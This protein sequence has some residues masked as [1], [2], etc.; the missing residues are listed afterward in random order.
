MEK[1]TGL[2]YAVK[3]IDISEA[4]HGSDIKESTHREIE[5]LRMVQGHPFVSKSFWVG[6]SRSALAL[7]TFQVEIHDRCFGKRESVLYCGIMVVRLGRS[8][9]DL[10][11]GQLSVQN[12]IEASCKY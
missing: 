2:E 5:V 1:E 3:I 8:S 6:Y 12:K 9:N 10:A 11:V 4:D 7:L